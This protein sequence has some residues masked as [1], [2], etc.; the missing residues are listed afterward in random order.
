M[1]SNIQIT[2]AIQGFAP[3]A[4]P[5][6]LVSESADEYA[7]LLVALQKEI[8]PKGVVEQIYLED[9]AAIIWE[10]QRLRRCKAGIV[11]SAYRAALE[12]LLQRLLLSPDLLDRITSESEAAELAQ[13]WF[14][15]KKCKRKVRALLNRYNLDETAIEAEAIRQS[16]SD[17]E[18]FERL[19][20]VQRSRLDKAL[21]C[22][23]EYRE[24]L[25][26]RMRESSDRILAD[27]DSICLQPV[28]SETN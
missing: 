24:S 16:W 21:G 18:S 9:I 11:N 27:G 5:P 10:I 22:V 7:A 14:V 2:K 3:L 19:L 17:L 4:P 20:M 15:N 6:L 25:A 23:A 28:P 1:S 13:G 12:S 8:M 26:V